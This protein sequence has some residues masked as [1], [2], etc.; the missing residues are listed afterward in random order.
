MKKTILAA[1]AMVFALVMVSCNSD[2]VVTTPDETG[3]LAFM[4]SN[5]VIDNGMTDVSV[6]GCTETDDFSIDIPMMEG[7]GRGNDKG[8]GGKGDEMRKLP[9]NFRGMPI[10]MGKILVEM[11]LTDDQKTLMKGFLDGFQECAKTARE[12]FKALAQPIL[13]NAR[14][15]RKAIM[16]R[17]KTD[18]TYTREQAR[19]D[20]KALNESVRQQLE[21][22]KYNDAFCLCLIGLLNN[23]ENN[24]NLTPEQLA[25][26]I[27]W[28]ATLKGPCF[29][30]IE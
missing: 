25:M 20:L 29:E 2:E 16:D 27:E 5:Y 14:V 19:A 23:I 24:L 10:H 15:E 30:T 9:V 6:Y 11:Q 18:D 4:S 17:L 3:T 28:K 21:D 8:R 22:L 1:A 26:F 12:D 7:N 13:E